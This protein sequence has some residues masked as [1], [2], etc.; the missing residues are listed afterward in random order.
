MYSS[1][2]VQCAAICVTY[3]GVTGIPEIYSQLDW[4]LEW[5]VYVS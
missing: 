5:G 4:G 3:L 2:Y 1:V